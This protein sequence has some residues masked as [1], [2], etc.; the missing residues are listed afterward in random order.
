MAVVNVSCALKKAEIRALLESQES[1]K[2]TFVS[3]KGIDQK[4]EVEDD[5]SIADLAGYTK[6]LITGQPWGAAL[7]L[8]VLMDGQAFSGQKI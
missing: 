5:G 1:P 3:E 4:F 8:R 7:F 6:K 2:Y